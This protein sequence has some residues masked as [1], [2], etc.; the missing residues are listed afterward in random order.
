M[1]RIT[2]AHP[3]LLLAILLCLPQAALAQTTHI[4]T[5]SDNSFSP[6]N[7]TIQVG[8]SVEFRNAAG[9]NSHNVVWQSGGFS[10]QPT[11]AAF[12]YT[13]T[14]NSAGTFNYECTIHNGMDGTITVQ[15]TAPPPEADLALTEISAPSGSFPQ[16]ASITIGADV[17]NV[18]G[19]ASSAYSID[20]YA[21]TN[22]GITSQ[23]RLL[24][25]QNRAA[26]AAGEDSNGTINV[27]IPGNLA[28]GNYF[29][30]GIIDINDA[31]NSNNDNVDNQPLT[32]TAASTFQINAGLNDSWFNPATDGQ[33][34][35]ITV[36]PNLETMFLAW[37]TY[38]LERPPGNVTA[39]LG[40]PGH[41]WLVAYGPYV[42]DTAT[43]EVTIAE[44]GIFD[45]SPPVPIQSP[46]GTIT[47]TFSSCTAGEVDYN[48]P[49][50]GRSGTVP[51]QRIA[52]DNV[53]F[54]EESS[55]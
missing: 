9:G 43:L 18:G 6:S 34:F 40:E 19:A 28:P 53:P 54:C 41:R 3:A 50:V 26:L 32:V 39:Q 47:V 27:N 24:G 21:S 46:D 48:I 12:T 16:G 51:I 11:A 52:N 45:D 22:S 36:F 23:D 20:F 14:F 2:I 49:S 10:N 31:N 44:G 1:Y 5:V 42:G 38:E 13:V 35:F 7:L 55:P 33:G 37:F 15:G 25:S 30:G 17:Q 8:D 4:V 29:I